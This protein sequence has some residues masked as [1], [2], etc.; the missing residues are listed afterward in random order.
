MS[1]EH[2]RSVAQVARQLGIPPNNPYKWRELFGEKGEEAFHGKG[3]LSSSDE[4]VR[5]LQQETMR[6]REERAIL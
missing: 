1:A 5:R 4:Q 6:L 3:H 2:H